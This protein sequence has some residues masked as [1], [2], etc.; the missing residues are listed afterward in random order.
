MM[1]LKQVMSCFRSPQLKAHVL[2]V[3]ENTFGPVCLL[4]LP[5]AIAHPP[6]ISGWE[7]EGFQ[8]EKLLYT[9]VLSALQ[10]QALKT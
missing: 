6:N 1:R 5:R 3:A 10:P 9:P 2:H 4:V 8:L 7:V